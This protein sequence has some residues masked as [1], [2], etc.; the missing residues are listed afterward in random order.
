MP[1]RPYTLKRSDGNIILNKKKDE[2]SGPP[3]FPAKSL[4]AIVCYRSEATKNSAT[5]PGPEC[6][7]TLVPISSMWIITSG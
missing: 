5:V 7:P 1:N 6:A 3:V 2:R 4:Y